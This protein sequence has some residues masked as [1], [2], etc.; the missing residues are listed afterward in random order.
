M[1]WWQW[2][3]PKSKIIAS[4]CRGGVGDREL[5]NSHDT[6]WDLAPVTTKLGLYSPKASL[7]KTVI[8]I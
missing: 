2:A 3:A 4:D 7:A 5:G 6:A 8:T 1:R